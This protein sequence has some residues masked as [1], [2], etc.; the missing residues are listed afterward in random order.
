MGGFTGCC[1]PPGVFPSPVK[2]GP[3]FLP[4]FPVFSLPPFLLAPHVQGPLVAFCV[5]VVETSFFPLLLD[6]CEEARTQTAGRG[7][8]LPLPPR[9]PARFN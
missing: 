8:E 1:F 9:C 5:V 3:R 2:P 4:P 6:V 7:T